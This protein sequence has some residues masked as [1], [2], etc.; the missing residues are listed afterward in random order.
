[1]QRTARTGLMAR[2]LER[3]ELCDVDP[4]LWVQGVMMFLLISWGA[5]IVDMTVKVR[6]SG[7]P[8]LLHHRSPEAGAT[9]PNWELKFADQ[10]AI[11]GLDSP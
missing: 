7:P 9:L 5:A 3:K 1:M 8:R 4:L 10:L 6:R 11:G 2:K